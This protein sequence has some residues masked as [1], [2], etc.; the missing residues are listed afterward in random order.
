MPR[1]ETLDELVHL[2]ERD[3]IVAV[4]AKQLRK[5]YGA[6]RLGR[7]IKS[8][9]SRALRGRQLAH[10]PE[11]IPDRQDQVV[12]VY[13]TT[14]FVDILVEAVLRPNK[15]SASRIKRAANA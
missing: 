7:H 11:K 14:G 4:T 3:E 8:A 15:G 1:F 10:L 9:I 2:V 5:M 12:L 6:D 13:L